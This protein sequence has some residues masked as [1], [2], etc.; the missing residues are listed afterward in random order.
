MNHSG[1]FL[2]S[3]SI[4]DLNVLNDLIVSINSELLFGENREVGSYKLAAKNKFVFNGHSLLILE[5]ISKAMH[6]LLEGALSYSIFT[7]MFA[8]KGAFIQNYD[9]CLFHKPQFL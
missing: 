5:N 9:S 7:D 4:S 2:K 6:F 8:H 3:F 1:T